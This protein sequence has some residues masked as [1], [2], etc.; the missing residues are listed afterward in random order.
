MGQV[1]CKATSEKKNQLLAVLYDEELRKGLDERSG[2]QISFCTNV[3]MERLSENG[4]VDENALRC[5]IAS[6]SSLFF[7]WPPSC[8]CSKEGHDPV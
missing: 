7:I 2:K 1:A 8:F 5:A 6:E 4:L 3:F